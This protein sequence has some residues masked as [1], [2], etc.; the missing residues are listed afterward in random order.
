VKPWAPLFHWSTGSVMSGQWRKPM[1]KL[2][3][4]LLPEHGPRGEAGH[5]NRYLLGTM[6]RLIQH[7]L[8]RSQGQAED[9]QHAVEAMESKKRI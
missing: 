1:P 8:K 5:W 4:R 3:T 2:A 7:H 6:P 9:G